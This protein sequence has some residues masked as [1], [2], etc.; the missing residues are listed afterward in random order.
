MKRHLAKR[1]P[2]HVRRAVTRLAQIGASDI[3][4]EVGRTFMV[5]WRVGAERMR[6]QAAMTPSG[7][8]FERLWASIRALFRARGLEVPA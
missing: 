1:Y 6:T 8:A 5:I 3:V 4:V 7:N 2:K